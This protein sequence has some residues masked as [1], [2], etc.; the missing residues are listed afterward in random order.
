MTSL[1]ACH[2]ALRGK[3]RFRLDLVAISGTVLAYKSL[4]M[5]ECNKTIRRQVMNAFR[6]AIRPAHG[7]FIDAGGISQAE[8]PTH[9]VL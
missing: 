4:S 5:P 8:M 9:V 7:N 6:V 1:D 3:L 2:S